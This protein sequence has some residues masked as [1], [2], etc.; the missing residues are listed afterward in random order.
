LTGA[1]GTVV[2]SS[3]TQQRDSLPLGRSGSGDTDLSQYERLRLLADARLSGQLSSAFEEHSRT[4]LAALEGDAVQD[5]LVVRGKVQKRVFGLPGMFT[6]RG[7]SA[8]EITD[9]LKYH[10]ANAYTVLDALHKAG[11]IELIDTVKPRRY[12]MTLKAPSRPHS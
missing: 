4:L 1:G 11:H 3:D 7:M 6:E 2:R 12:R 9:E 8:G 10:E 5:E